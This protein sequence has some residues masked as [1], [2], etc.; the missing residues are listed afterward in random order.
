MEGKK[1]NKQTLL[2]CVEVWLHRLPGFADL[3]MKYNFFIFG[4]IKERIHVEV[5]K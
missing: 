5:L 2:E 1:E 3:V 4:S